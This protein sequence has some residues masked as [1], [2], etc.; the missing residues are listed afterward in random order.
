MELTSPR[1]QEMAGYLP[2]FYEQ[3]RIMEELLEAEGAEFDL[4]RQ[5]IEE[6]LQQWFARTAT[7]GLDAWE[8]FLELPRQ[9]GLLDSERQDRAVAKLRGFGVANKA[10]IEQVAESYTYGEVEAFDQN[11]GEPAYTIR[12]EFISETGI[13]SNLIDLQNAV[14]AVVPAHLGI[15]YT[16]NWTTWNEIDTID[17]GAPHTW[18]EWDTAD[19][20]GPY[21]WDEME[22]LV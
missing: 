1:G 13:P 15:T 12:I 9:Q 14:R 21:T 20:G 4:L 7:W 22:E 10:L 6:L 5:A 2:E 18:D 11:D 19:A 16:Y 8:V 17:A 3:S